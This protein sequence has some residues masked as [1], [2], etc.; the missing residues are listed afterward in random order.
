MNKPTVIDANC[1]NYFQNERILDTRG[2][3]SVAIDLVFQFGHI[4]IDDEY[5]AIQ[6][7]VDCAEG[8]A[9]LNLGDWIA[10]QMATQKIIPYQ[11]HKDQNLRKH[12]RLVGLQRKDHKWIFIAIGAGSE[13]I[14]TNDVDL[15][16]PDGKSKTAGAQEK[17][18]RCRQGS[19]C[20]EL[21]KRYGI[22]LSI[23]EGVD[24]FLCG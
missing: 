4:A 10:D 17:I 2:P 15:F 13:L 6:E 7:Y 24:D 16:Q 3:V 21:R 23:P 22:H 8:P 12:L 18:K 14:I 19:L 11:M 20:K 1:L 5:Q 9:A